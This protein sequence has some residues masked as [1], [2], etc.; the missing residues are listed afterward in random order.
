MRAAFLTLGCKVNYYE[1]E[2]MILDFS[3]HGFTIVDF[4]RSADIYIV[5]TCTVTNIAD[6]KSRQMLHRARKN[7]PSA[8]I[9]AVGCYVDGVKRENRAADIFEEEGILAF[10]NEDKPEL[11]AKLTDILKNDTISVHNNKPSNENERTRAFIKVQDGCN[12]FCSYC[13]IP[14][15]RGGGR[16][17]SV[18]V[19]EV[20]DEVRRYASLSRREIVLTGIHLSSYGITDPMRDAFTSDGGRHLSELILRVAEVPGID[21]IRLGSLEPR[22]I[23]ESFL[24]ALT[25]CEKLMPHFHLSLQSGCDSVLTNMNRRYTTDEYQKST[26]LIRKYYDRPAITTDVIVG[27]PG[28][29]DEDF[30]Q[31]LEFVKKIGFADLHVF[32]YS[33]RDGT[34]ASRMS[35]Q[36]APEVKKERSERLIETGE[37]LRKKYIASLAGLVPDIL[38]EEEAEYGGEKYLAGFSK[39]YVRYG[40]KMEDAARLGIKAGMIKRTERAELIMK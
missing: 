15:V 9:V 16:L 36:I 6:R 34:K 37:L 18:P 29:S 11:A 13:L 38:F 5:N 12:Q 39:R 31:T 40:L 4:D 27:F 35:G 3:E 28:E 8:L 7:N 24:D 2:K 22:I 21:R 10:G 32:Q 33:M 25:G 30:T 19:D 1:T 17:S 23:S 26:E 20:L 14:Y